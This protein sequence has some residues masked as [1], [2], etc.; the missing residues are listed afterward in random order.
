MRQ[1]VF[2]LFAILLLA[3]SLV[4]GW[5]WWE[6]KVFLET[7]LKTG[8]S[9]ITYIVQSGTN[10]TRVAHELERKDIISNAR[11]LLWH[12][13]L[14]HL[15]AVK[16][17]EYHIEVGTVPGEL[18]AQLNA[19]RVIQYAVT[20]IEGWTFQELLEALHDHPVLEK[21]L[22]GLPKNQVLTLL[23]I[24]E[25]HP[26]GLF[27]PDTYHFPKGTTDIEFLKRAYR[28]M[29]NTLKQE[30]EARSVGLPFENPYEAL[31]MASIV[32]KETGLAIERK[33]IAGVFIR[34]LEKRMRLQSDPTVIY[35]LGSRFDG[36]I[37]RR[38]LR[39]ST[40]YNTYRIKGLPP[41]PIALPGQD[42]IHATLHPDQGQSLYFVSRGDGSHHFSDT[43]EEHN[44]AVIRFQLNGKRRSF[45]SFKTQQQKK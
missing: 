6:Y 32:E 4:V 10:L 20:V 15:S 29:K 16:T 1:F 19:G 7:P 25:K 28:A 45:S 2:R 38:D 21:K 13:R 37:R 14:N 44:E 43:L 34:R 8:E 22:A 39:K 5:L 3:G 17:G 9:G 33:Q 26:E 41:T 30:W 27:L 42:A 23:G 12:A 35:G 40:P 31:T 18:L 36:N 24:K 11:F